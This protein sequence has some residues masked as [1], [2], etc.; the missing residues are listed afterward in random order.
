MTDCSCR[1]IDVRQV[2]V[3]DID[4]TALDLT[5]FPSKKKPE[6]GH[7]YKADRYYR[8]EYEVVIVPEDDLGYMHFKVLVKGEQVGEAR[9]RIGG[10]VEE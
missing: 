10:K 4:L 9:L 8:V 5:T 3:I 6:T 1:P 2:R 7:P